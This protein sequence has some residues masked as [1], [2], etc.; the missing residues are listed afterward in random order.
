[1]G[2]KP[3]PTDPDALLSLVQRVKENYQE[4]PPPPPKRG[5]KRDFTG[6]SFLL[7]AA[8]AV[9]LRTFS[10]SEL[11]KLLEKEERLRRALGFE[12]VPHRTCIG[13]RLSGLVLEAEQQIALLGKQLVEEVKP[14]ADQPK[15]S[16]IDGRMY[17]AQSPK[18]HKSDR[19]KGLVPDGVRNVD[20]DSKWSKRFLCPIC[21]NW[22]A[23]SS[24]RLGSFRVMKL[25][26][27]PCRNSRTGASATGR[28]GYR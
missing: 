8:V 10:D 20:T 14:E 3:T 16:A 23:P 25:S 21:P 19:Q 1:M 2:T 18:W 11:R 9:T 15:A 17:K 28:L 6:L 7:L 5:K 26:P 24:C 4:P 27:I 13:R 12:R 22:I